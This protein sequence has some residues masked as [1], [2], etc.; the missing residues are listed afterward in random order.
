MTTLDDVFEQMQ[1]FERAL[2]EFN[3]ALRLSA[4]DMRKS[5]EEIRALW[6]DKAA[7]QYRRIYEPLANSLDLYLRID[8]PRFEA[9]LQAKVRQLDIFLHGQ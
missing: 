7:V 9:F 2:V 6:L 3:E 4:Q 8:V 5:D 1:I